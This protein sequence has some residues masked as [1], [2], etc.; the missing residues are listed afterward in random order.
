[1]ITTTF[2]VL[3]ENG[4][5]TAR[6]KHLAKALGGIATYGKTTP[7]PLLEILETNGLDDALWAL[8][9][10]KLS[11]EDE[12]K[13]HLLACDFAEH[14]I[15]IYEN[16]YPE[17]KRPRNAIKVK[18][19]WV[20]GESDDAA[21]DAAR[22]AARAA[23]GGAALAEARDAAS[24]AARAAAWGAAGDAASAA[25]RAAAWGAAWGAAGDAAGDSEMKWQ[26]EKLREMLE[27]CNDTE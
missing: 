4:A 5:C 26:E 2:K 23:A 9:V 12:K 7:I 27:S 22:A 17:D 14:T 3:R 18:R 21:S 1:M 10:C 13:M 24:A 16:Y 6:Y 19:K 15:H 8:R 20:N 11:E 25:A